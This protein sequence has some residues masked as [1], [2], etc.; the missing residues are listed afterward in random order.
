[1]K[2]F[3]FFKKKKTTFFRPT[4]TQINSMYKLLILN[5]NLM[6]NQSI[7]P[8]TKKNYILYTSIKL[9]DYR[10]KKNCI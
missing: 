6:L 4:Y 2:S 10:G 1:M 8:F 7:T 3:F 5:S 9:E